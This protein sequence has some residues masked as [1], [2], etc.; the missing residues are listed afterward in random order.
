MSTGTLSLICLKIVRWTGWLLLPMVAA[1]FATGYAIS[2]RYGFGALTDENTAL[3]LHKLMH[4][5]LVTLM[6]T[7]IVPSTYLALVRWGWI[8]QH[9]KP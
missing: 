6:V 5:P 4:L 1:F 9:P 3:E 8:K 2:D 7:H